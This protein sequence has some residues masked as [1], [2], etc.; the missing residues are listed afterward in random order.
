ME[1]G[2]GYLKH[3]LKGGKQGVVSRLTCSCGAV[4]EFVRLGLSLFFLCGGR[5]PAPLAAPLAA[6]PTMAPRGRSGP[7]PVLQNVK[8]R[9][10]SDAALGP[11]AAPQ[12]FTEDTRKRISHLE[13]AL[14]STHDLEAQYKS[15]MQEVA[16]IDPSGTVFDGVGPRWGGAQALP[17]SL[18]PIDQSDLIPSDPDG[19][20]PAASAAAAAGGGGLGGAPASA[21]GVGDDGTGPSAEDDEVARLGMTAGG[22]GGGAAAS[23]PLRNTPSPVIIWRHAAPVKIASNVPADLLAAEGAGIGGAG[24]GRASP[25]GL[26]RADLVARGRR[27]RRWRRSGLASRRRR[28][29]ARRRCAIRARSVA[30]RARPPRASLS[31]RP[32]PPRPRSPAPPPRRA[33]RTRGD[34][35]RRLVPPSSGE[36]AWRPRRPAAASLGAPD[37]TKRGGGAKSGG[38]GGAGGSGSGALVSDGLGEETDGQSLAD[39]IPKLYSSQ[40]YKEFLK[41]ECNLTGAQIPYYL[42]RVDLPK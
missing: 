3:N 26:V 35:P 2:A 40:K 15:F 31:P 4:K 10:L 8:W 22:G 41:E 34:C 25:G 32:L 7:N 29:F 36:A 28:R 16:K 6:L 5:F 33:S 23:D 38:G 14:A 42:E 21:D 39:T 13:S 24:G 12:P 9:F 11:N 20:P 17:G 18:P 1:K 37:G 27:R 19:A 30:T